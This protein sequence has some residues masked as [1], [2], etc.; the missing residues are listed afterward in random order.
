MGIVWKERSLSGRVKINIFEDV[1]VPLMYEFQAW[2][3]RCGCM[4]EGRCVGSKMLEN[5]MFCGEG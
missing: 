3:Y 4:E 5:S 2:A 1:V